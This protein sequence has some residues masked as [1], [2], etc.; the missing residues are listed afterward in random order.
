LPHRMR[1]PHQHPD[2]PM[3]ADRSDLRRGQ[4]HLKETAGKG[5]LCT[6]GLGKAVMPNQRSG[7][8]RPNAN[9]VL[10]LDMFPLPLVSR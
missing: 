6:S 7:L 4:A 2:V 5:V 1:V 10:S 8:A 3:A 9:H